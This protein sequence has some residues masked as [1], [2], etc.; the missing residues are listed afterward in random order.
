M[1]KS[2]VIEKGITEFRVTFPEVTEDGEVGEFEFTL[3]AQ[4]HAD[5]GFRENGHSVGFAA[6]DESNL[7]YDDRVCLGWFSVTKEELGWFVDQLHEAVHG[8]EGGANG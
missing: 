1:K 3:R 5:K 7:I 4:F 8:E 2:L 6:T